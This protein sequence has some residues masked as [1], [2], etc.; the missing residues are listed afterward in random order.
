VEGGHSWPVGLRL[1]AP[2][3]DTIAVKDFH[4]QRRPDGRWN[5]HNVPLGEGMVDFRAYLP[6]L[7][8]LRALPPVT[9]HFEYEPLEMNGGGGAARRR[10]TVAGMRRDLSRFESLL[11]AA[12][13]RSPSSTSP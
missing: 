7:L 9:M 13:M 5:I 12:S 2:H 6:Q 3:I 1:I 4:W 10:D 8:A 11:A